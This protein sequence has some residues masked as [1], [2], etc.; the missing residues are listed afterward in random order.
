MG[1]PP[2]GDQEL[3]LLHHLAEAGPCSVGEAAEAWGGR[4]DLARSTVL[5]VMER[6]RKKGYLVR[7]QVGGIFRYRSVEA[8]AEL[9]RGV[10]GRFVERSLGGSVSPFVA[11]LAEAPGDVSPA[12][13]ARLEALV[14]KLKD[15]P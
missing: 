12:D 11:W 14:Q 7:R 8:P 13:V 4:H 6:L 3:A 10:V 1:K 2:L 15:R 5:T 9:L